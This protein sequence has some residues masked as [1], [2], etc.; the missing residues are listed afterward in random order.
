M[1][2]DPCKSKIEFINNLINMYITEDDII[3][4]DEK[5]RVSAIFEALGDE[6]NIDI[7]IKLMLLTRLI[8]KYGIIKK[9]EF[10]NY[11]ENIKVCS[12]EENKYN[13]KGNCDL[14]L[15]MLIKIMRLDLILHVLD[16]SFTIH[17]KIN[18][19][20]NFNTDNSV[21]DS[22]NIIANINVLPVNID[23][24]AKSITL[25]NKNKITVADDGKLSDTSF[26]KSIENI[27]KFLIDKKLNDINMDEKI[28]IYTI[29]HILIKSF[30]TK[31]IQVNFIYKKIIMNEATRCAPRSVFDTLKQGGYNNKSGDIEYQICKCNF[32]Q[33]I[34]KVSAKSAREAAK[35]VANKVLK[36]DK[37]SITFSLKRIIGKKEKCYDYNASIDKSG[38]ILIKSQ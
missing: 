15:I 28:H 13:S 26:Y 11:L 1:A 9:D 25:Y 24:G 18:Q 4:E 5:I 32:K 17:Q 36:G 29:L 21:T 19:G 22:A 34:K 30:Y 23:I 37:K 6:D 20:V 31:N 16:N 14:D 33:N 2:V 7:K 10:Y 27:Y 12:I 8:D 35:I 3:N 38:K